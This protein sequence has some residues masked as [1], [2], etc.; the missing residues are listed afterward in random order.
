MKIAI[1]ITNT[2]EFSAHYGASCR[3]A[4]FEADDITRAI[5]IESVLTPT[6]GSP[7]S[8]PDW[9]QSEGVTVMLVGGMGGGALARCEALGIRVIA[10]MP[11]TTPVKLAAAYLDGTLQP[12]ESACQHG[13]HEHEQGHA[14]GHDHDHEHGGHCNCAH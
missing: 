3:L 7:C 10:G 9:L 4:C 2:H 11:V 8:W 14:H 6:D 1:P 13:D 5:R 12:G